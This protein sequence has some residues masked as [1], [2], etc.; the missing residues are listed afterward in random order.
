M[1]DLCCATLQQIFVSFPVTS[2]NYLERT[3]QGK[4]LIG[5]QIGFLELNVNDSAVWSFNERYYHI[6]INIFDR[7]FFVL[8]RNF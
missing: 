8:L 3:D 2:G 7:T 4:A 6:S 1:Y 5:Y